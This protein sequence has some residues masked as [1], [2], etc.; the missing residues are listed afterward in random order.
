MALKITSVGNPSEDWTGTVVQYHATPAGATG[1]NH[2]PPS[3]FPV[4]GTATLTE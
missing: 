3:D 4:L 1:G 2:T